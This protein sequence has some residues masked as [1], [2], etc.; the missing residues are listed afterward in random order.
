[1]ITWFP[2]EMRSPVSSDL[3]NPRNPPTPVLPAGLAAW[4]GSAPLPS[5]RLDGL[6]TG[7][8]LA[9]EEVNTRAVDTRGAG[10]TPTRRTAA[11]ATRAPAPRSGSQGTPRVSD[12]DCHMATRPQTPQPTQARTQI[13]RA[14][15]TDWA[16][17]TAIRAVDPARE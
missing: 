3:A 13:P 15:S 11:T 12:S 16:A 7:E 10:R 2:R 8:E 4:A 9:A 6:S 17:A 5:V 1:M 14:R